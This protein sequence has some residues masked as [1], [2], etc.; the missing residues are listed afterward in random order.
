MLSFNLY[1]IGQPYTSHELPPLVGSCTLF[2]T[3]C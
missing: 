3:T 1:F 2:P